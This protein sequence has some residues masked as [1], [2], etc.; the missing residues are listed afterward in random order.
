MTAYPEVTVS[1]TSKHCRQAVI[2]LQ[3]SFP[4]LAGYFA[5]LCTIKPGTGER[6]TF[7][8]FR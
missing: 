3:N 8:A 2:L 1:G 7:D 5:N 4:R 6:A